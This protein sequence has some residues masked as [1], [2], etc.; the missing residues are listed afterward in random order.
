[1]M[2]MHGLRVRA[3]CLFVLVEGS[4]E[5]GG[6]SHTET[7]TQTITILAQAVTNPP[8]YREREKVRAAQQPN[9][10]PEI[11]RQPWPPADQTRHP[12]PKVWTRE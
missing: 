11:G 3:W 10:Q 4:V 8:R 6:V 9:A 2:G 5:K 7:H 1:V 12:T